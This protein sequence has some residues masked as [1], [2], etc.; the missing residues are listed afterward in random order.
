[1]NPF[2]DPWAAEIAILPE[3]KKVVHLGILPPSDLEAHAL[4]QLAGVKLPHR[5]LRGHREVSNVRP[6][7]MLQC[8]R[9]GGA[10]GNFTRVH[11][12]W[13]L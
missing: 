7:A 12:L 6:G 1:M 4:A 8:C 11:H 10:A 2:G 13:C 5:R 9:G 3:K